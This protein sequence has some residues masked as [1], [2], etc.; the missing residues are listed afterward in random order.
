VFSSALLGRQERRT[1]TVCR[2][3]LMCRAASG[4]YYVRGYWHQQALGQYLERS[5]QAERQGR[6][7]QE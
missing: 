3:K 7:G 6:Q 5:Q 4:V 1:E 2:V